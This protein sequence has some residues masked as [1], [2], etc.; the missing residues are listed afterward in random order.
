MFVG[1]KDF[2][3]RYKAPGHFCFSLVVCVCLCV[4]MP[5]CV[6]VCVLFDMCYHAAVPYVGYMKRTT[7]QSLVYQKVTAQ[8][9]YFE[10]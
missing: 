4:C 1:T 9:E 6:C 8:L 7:H 5:V 2:K 3:K 10:C